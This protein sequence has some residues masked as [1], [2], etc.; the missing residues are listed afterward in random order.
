[1]TAGADGSF[2]LRLGT[3]E[4]ELYAFGLNAKPWDTAIRL[5]ALGHYV[6]DQ[7]G[8]QRKDERSER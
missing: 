8:D 2:S 4:T 7:P 5:C 1:M 3:Q 6:D